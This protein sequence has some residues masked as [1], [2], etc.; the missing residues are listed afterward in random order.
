MSVARYEEG[1]EVVNK[2]LGVP[3]N[4]HGDRCLMAFE[5]KRMRAFSLW[6][7]RDDSSCQL[8]DV[9]AKPTLMLCSG[10]IDIC[11]SEFSRRIEQEA[12]PMPNPMIRFQLYITKKQ[13]DMLNDSSRESGESQGELIRRAIDEYF[14]VRKDDMPTRC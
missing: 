7:L 11:L 12:H 14:G 4:W 13:K 2:L 9:T 10:A 8:W 1:G 6:R 5:D 3:Y